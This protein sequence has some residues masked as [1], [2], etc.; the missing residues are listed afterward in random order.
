MMLDPTVLDALD[1]LVDLLDAQSRAIRLATEATETY[2]ET[3]EADGTASRGLLEMLGGE[4]SGS[5]DPEDHQVPDDE[6]RAERNALTSTAC[7]QE[8]SR[9]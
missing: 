8:H 5:S 6:E 3:S 4:H 2:L 7:N 1:K 9:R